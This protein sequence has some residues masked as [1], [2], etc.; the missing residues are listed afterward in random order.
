MSSFTAV[1]AHTPEEC[2][3]PFQSL[4]NFSSPSLFISLFM[5]NH[6]LP[7]GCLSQTTKHQK[8]KLCCYSRRQGGPGYLSQAT[9]HQ[10]RK[11]CYY[12]RRGGVCHL[13]LPGIQAISKD[14]HLSP[15]NRWLE[16]T[17]PYNVWPYFSACSTGRL[18]ESSI[19]LLRDRK[20]DILESQKMCICTPRFP[21]KSS[22]AFE[23]VIQ[24]WENGFLSGK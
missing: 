10:K 18:S 2:H 22:P 5:V 6:Q 8:R 11:L 9:K 1:A 14:A 24:W 16:T 21:P 12:S 17:H 7:T 15:P 20:G 23:D 13:N 19:G 4:L 3:S